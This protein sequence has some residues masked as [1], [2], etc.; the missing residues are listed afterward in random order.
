MKVDTIFRTFDGRN[1]EPFRDVAAALP[2]TPE[3]LSLLLAMTRDPDDRLRFGSTWV[4]K[5]WILAG[6]AVDGRNAG[7]LIRALDDPDTPAMAIVNLLQA[8][9]GVRIP[10][11]QAER[12]HD[13]LGRLA[14]S[15]VP[16]V[17]AWAFNGLDVLAVQRPEYR[18]LIAPRLVQ[19]ESDPAASVRARMRRRRRERPKD[20]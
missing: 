5:D 2:R 18:D 16:F 11:S 12:L 8:L 15:P 7:R 14:E 20:G 9:P 13:A 4:L 6:V 10:T 19:A 17:R 1:T 3:S